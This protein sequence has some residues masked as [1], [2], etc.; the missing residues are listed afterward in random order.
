[1][2][3]WTRAEIVSRIITECDAVG[4]PRRVGLGCGIAESG[5]RQYAERWGYH[6]AEGI[7]AAETP[8]IDDDQAVLDQLDADG[9]PLDVSFGVGQQIVRYA[10][11]GDGTM[12][13]ANVLAVRAWLFDPANAI[14]LMVTKLGLFFHDRT[15]PGIGD[16]G[17]GLYAL[18]RYNTGR[19]VAPGGQFAGNVANYGRALL[20]ADAE[21]ATWEGD[22]VDLPAIRTQLDAI[23]GLSRQLEGRRPS[24]ATLAQIAH[25]LQASVRAIKD[26]AGLN[27]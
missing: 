20:A 4:L 16:E 12:T 2:R 3:D 23:W 5:L 25:Q 10:P 7:R 22:D 26:G 27:G 8:D 18:Y 11:V 17:R 21:L 6:T 15:N 14:S 19:F 13:P 9:T 24:A 1:M